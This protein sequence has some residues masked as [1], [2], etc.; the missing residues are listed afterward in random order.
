MGRPGG[1][2]G[3]RQDRRRLPA[4]RQLGERRRILQDGDGSRRRRHQQRQRRPGEDHAAGQGRRPAGPEGR[5]DPAHLRRQPGHAGGRPEPDAAADHRGEG[6]RRARRLPVGHHAHRQRHRRTLRHSL[7]DAG[8]RRGQP[9]RARLQVVLPHHAGRHRFRAGLFGVPEGAEGR[10][11][12][13]RLGGPGAREHRVRQFGRQR[14]R[15][16][17][18]QGRSFDHPE[19][20]LL[21]QFDRRAAAGAAAQGEES[22]RR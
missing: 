18:R 4:E 2:P 17:V 19:H 21:G 9:D 6:R 13:G 8:V 22:R 5:Q 16:G 7:P 15:R 1:R 10:R 14:H 11:P 12:Q 3:H 20:L